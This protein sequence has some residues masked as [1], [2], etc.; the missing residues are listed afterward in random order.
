MSDLIEFHDRSLSLGLARVA[1]QAAIASAKLIGRGDEK[2]AGGG[3]LGCGIR[4]RDELA[5]WV[6]E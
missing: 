1:E 3:R 5:G 2:A 6:L 4:S